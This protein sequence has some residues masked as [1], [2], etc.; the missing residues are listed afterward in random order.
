M[1]GAR[2]E[3]LRDVSAS[4]AEYER[5]L[6]LA[7]PEGLTGGPHA[8]SVARGNVHLDVSLSPGPERVIALVRLQTLSVR[9]SFSGGTE[10]EQEAML[11]HM[12]LAMRRGGG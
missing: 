4:P 12:D 11:R 2:R 9:L 7:F 1:P 8:F 6:R 5:T 3:L 10:A